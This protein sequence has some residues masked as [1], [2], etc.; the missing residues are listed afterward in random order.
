MA[1]CTSNLPRSVQLYSEALGFRDAGGGAFFGELLGCI[2]Q[3]GDDAAAVLWWLVGG[4]ERFQIEL[5]AHTDPPQRPQSRDWR[6]SDLG[7][8]RW[9]IEV[10]DLNACLAALAELSIAPLTAPLV[11]ADRRR[12]CIRDPWTAI[13]LELIEAAGDRSR[14]PRV[15]YGAVSV[16]DLDRARAF[17]V[18][19]AGLEEDRETVLHSAAH[20]ALWGLEGARSSGFLVRAGEVLLEVVRY[21]RPVGR[22]RPADALLSDQGFMH[23]AIGVREKPALEALAGRFAAHGYELTHPLPPGGS[24][25]TYVLDDTGLTIEIVAVPPALEQGY[26]FVAKDSSPF[27]EDGAPPQPAAQID[28]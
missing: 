26:G 7:W 8:V 4:Q 25:G 16:P 13:P 18:D 14:L 23:M 11:E 2:Q 3:L 24:G 17:Y 22:P 21:E 9:G 20:E 27:V 6:P 28:V 1:L 15:V 19:G 12:V 5:F 10:A